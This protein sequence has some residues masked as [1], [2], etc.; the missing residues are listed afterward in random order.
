VYVRCVAGDACFERLRQR[1]TNSLTYR[2]RRVR[3]ITGIDLEDASRRA[4]LHRQPL[5]L[6]S[7]REGA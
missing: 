3:E 6:R 7:Q 2:R 5:I 1:H 4:G